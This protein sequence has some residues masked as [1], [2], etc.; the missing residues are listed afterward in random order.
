MANSGPHTNSSQFYITTTKTDWLDGKHVVF[1]EVIEGMEIIRKL[2]KLGSSSGRTS[3]KVWI[4][5]CGELQQ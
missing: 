1:G 2:E 3:K 5:A 4:S